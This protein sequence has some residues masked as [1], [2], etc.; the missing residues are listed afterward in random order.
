MFVVASIGI[1]FFNRN[2]AAAIR[3]FL[4][5]TVIH[6]SAVIVLC[7]VTMAPSLDWNWLGG[8]IALAGA[9]GIIYAVFVAV[10]VWRRRE[11]VLVD[12]FWYGLAPLAGY[13]FILAA[14]VLIVLRKPL[15][16]ELT[17]IGMVLMILCGVRNSWDMI[18]FILTRERTEPQE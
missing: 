10:D 14:A 11:L 3:S 8:C 9:A 13:F 17:G 4:T 1:G 18:V 7:L 12:H 5:P 16:M 15:A 6:L 2:H